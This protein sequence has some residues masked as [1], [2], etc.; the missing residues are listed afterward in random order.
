MLLGLA[1]AL[2]LAI[3]MPLSS[4]FVHIFDLR[5]VLPSLPYSHDVDLE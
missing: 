3:E 4:P 2:A 5:F 1:L